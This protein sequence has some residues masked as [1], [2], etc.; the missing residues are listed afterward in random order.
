MPKTDKV[1]DILALATMSE[2]AKIARLS[3]QKVGKVFTMEHALAV[4]RTYFGDAVRGRTREVTTKLFNEKHRQERLRNDRQAVK[5]AREARLGSYTQRLNTPEAR[6]AERIRHA[7]G[8]FGRDIETNFGE[9]NLALMALI[10]GD[11]RR[12]T[13]RW[14]DG[15]TSPVRSTVIEVGVI[16]DGAFQSQHR[17]LLY[18]HEDRTMV[19]GTGYT[20]V[21]DALA[22]Q[23]PYKLLT[24]AADLKAQGCT[25]R[26]D[27]AMQ[28]MVITTPE[29][30]EKRLP[31]TGRTVED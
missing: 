17:V 12:Y 7:Q 22:G 20:N 25:I 5:G 26:S 1:L 31:W 23:V 28:E 10:Q 14:L 4:V 15:A 9:D 18:K 8:T 30:E 6:N 21:Q 24:L 11:I 29:G 16:V 2:D 3:S 19:A 27:F 13:V